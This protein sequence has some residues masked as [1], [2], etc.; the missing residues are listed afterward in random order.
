MLIVIVTFE[1]DGSATLRD[2][3]QRFLSTAPRYQDMPGLLRKNYIVSA[4]AKTAGGV[5][6]WE[7][8]AQADSLYTAEFRQFIRN[9]YHCE[10]DIRYFESP[11]MV[12]NVAQAIT[13]ARE[14]AAV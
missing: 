5:Y 3:A 9:N 10:P 8:K 2:M 1:L 6:V 12:D 11:V 4:D 7:S 14:Y 13:C